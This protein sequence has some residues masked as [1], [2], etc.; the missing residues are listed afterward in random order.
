MGGRPGSRAGR[1]RRA[2]AAGVGSEE[3]LPNPLPSTVRGPLAGLVD[4]AAALRDPASPASTFLR[5]LAA[6]AL[7][8]AAIA[9]ARRWRRRRRR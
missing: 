6:G 1:A 3:G 2:A 5:G 9:G 7:V 4:L 8:G